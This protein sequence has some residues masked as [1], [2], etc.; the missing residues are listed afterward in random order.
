MDKENPPSIKLPI[1]GFGSTSLIPAEFQAS[2]SR[3]HEHWSQA[4]NALEGVARVLFHFAPPK[5]RLD[6][7]S[8]WKLADRRLKMIEAAQKLFAG[9]GWF[10]AH[11]VKQ[12]DSLQELQAPRNAI[13]HGKAALRA[14]MTEQGL[15]TKVRFANGNGTFEF[16]E[17]ELHEIANR[18]SAVAGAI[19][20]LKHFHILPVD[21]REDSEQAS[22]R[23]K[24]LE[25]QAATGKQAW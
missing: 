25:Y 3:V 15:E 5:G 13:S 1:Y 11:L 14:T 21:F 20:T 4:E 17:V 18:L 8:H 12:F 23:Q 2:L 9:D 24:L 6:N 16:T 7:L 10:V 19:S 22:W